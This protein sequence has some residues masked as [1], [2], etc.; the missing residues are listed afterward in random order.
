MDNQDL[1]FAA[2]AGYPEELWH[3]KLSP[4]SPEKQQHPKLS[5]EMNLENTD[6]AQLRAM[7]MER[8]TK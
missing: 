2:Y 8:Q 3:N 4:K 7:M 5:D 6:R 1:Q